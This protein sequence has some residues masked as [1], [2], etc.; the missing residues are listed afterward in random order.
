MSPQD[1][2]REYYPALKEQL[3]IIKALTDGMRD[4]T[5][6]TKEESDALTASIRKLAEIVAEVK[7]ILDT[8]PS[9][10]DFPDCSELME[11]MAPVQQ[12]IAF[13]KS[14]ISLQSFADKVAM[15]YRPVPPELLKVLEMILGPEAGKMLKQILPP[16]VGYHGPT[17]TPTDPNGDYDLQQLA[18]QLGINLSNPED[19]AEG[20]NA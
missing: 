8:L 20:L 13:A 2:V 5:P 6:P 3:R 17:V 19:E 1:Q 12:W 9:T 4:N 15:A 18:Q 7:K 10:R 11:E 14:V 16:G